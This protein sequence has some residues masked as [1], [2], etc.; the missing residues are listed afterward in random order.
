MP[1]VYASD[2]PDMTDHE[3]RTSAFGGD[4]F[5]YT[6]T[7][8]TLALCAYAQEVLEQMLG[9]DPPWAQQRMS[10]HDF[11]VLFDAAVVHYTRRP[12]V[13]EH[14]RAVLADLGC[15]LHSTYVS[16]PDLVAITGQGFL[17]YG[18]GRPQHPH[19]DT[20]YAS[21]PSE[22]HWWVPLYDTGATASLAFHPRYWDWP[23]VNNSVDFDYEKWKLHT[24]RTEE[25][26]VRLSEPRPLE[27]VTL[28]PV[29]RIASPAGGLLVFSAAQFYSIVPNDSSNTHFATY[30]QTV[31]EKD[32][33]EGFGARNLD[34]EPQGTT[35]T[36]FLR[37]DDFSPIP[38][39]LVALATAQ[40]RS[41][42]E[43]ADQ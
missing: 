20:W 19:R 24:A 3:R 13:M 35:L 18:M 25:A 27:T 28:D 4:F 22:L 8:A 7:S 6:P 17:A 39:E 21:S 14:I 37:C 23:V 43:L 26:L 15:D 11:T 40:Y 34:A 41:R 5:V 16:S 36:G 12:S 42:E 33:R 1:I 31:S 38:E 30:F 2:R 29:I 9:A 32:L 10:E